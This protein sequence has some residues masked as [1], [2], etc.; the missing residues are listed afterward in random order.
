[1]NLYNFNNSINIGNAGEEI[2]KKH[3]ESLSNVNN[4]TDVSGDSK[5][6]DLDI[7]LL[8]DFSDGTS[9]SV[10][11]KTDT[12][13]SGNIFFETMSNLEANVLGCMYKTKA[14]Y[15]FY[16]FTETKELYIMSMSRYLAW[17]EANKNRFKEKKLRNVNRRNNG[18]YTTVGYTIPKSF[19]E[20]NFKNYKKRI[21][22]A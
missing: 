15:L 13:N 22:E 4:I 10:E 8:I 11:I 20:K 21:L 2:V 17:F 12:Y 16:Y 9:C 18:F 7:D 5:Y 3:I 19:L 1:M 14:D 6:Q